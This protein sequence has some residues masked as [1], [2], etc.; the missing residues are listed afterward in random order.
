MISMRQT[1]KALAQFMPRVCVAWARYPREKIFLSGWLAYDKA[2]PSV[3]FFTSHK[4]ASMLLWRIL[5]DMN[6]RRM[7]LTPL[8]FP[9]YW[10]DV[11]SDSFY[12][13]VNSVGQC[14]IRDTGI[15][16]APF[17]EY[18]EVDHLK[19][20]RILCMLRDPRDKLVSGYYSAKIS[21]RPPVNSDRR[22]AFLGNRARLQQIS[23]D[24]Y[25][26]EQ[27]PRVKRIYRQYRE[28][29]ARDHVL[30]YEQMWSDF[31]GWI[32]QLSSLL[33]IELSEKE[34]ES[35]RRM[36]GVDDEIIENASAHRRRGSPGDHRH[37]LQLSTIESLDQIFADEL[38]WLYGE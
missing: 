17:R 4:C 21:H 24:E 38:I 7:K 10:F 16:Y 9:G 1:A 2:T 18:I 35:Y 31:N 27:A 11:R 30:T 13:Y 14:L 6:R 5:L 8:N 20:A 15:L 34:I 25:V 36:S 23:I 37:K 32:G 22:R 3:F 12:Y 26:I 28:N 19:H 33:G 29:L